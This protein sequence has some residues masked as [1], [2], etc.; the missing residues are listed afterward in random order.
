MDLLEAMRTRSSTRAFLERPVERATVEAILEA[1]RWAP[2]GVNIQPWRV[3]VVQGESRGRIAAAIAAA[4]AAGQAPNPDY[5]YYPQQWRE[6]YKER[7]KRCGLA[8]Y[9]ALGVGRDDTDAR[10]AAWERNYRFFDAPVGLLVFLERD[11]GQGAWVDLGMFIQN[12]LLAALPFGLATCPQAAMA[13]YPDIVREL[14]GVEPR[15]A[16]MCGIALGYPDPDAPVNRYRT[17]RE[18]VAEFAAFYE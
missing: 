3:A 12:V 9:R 11:L 4:R 18:P 5:T 16:L 7:R 14:L 8:M 17:E 1:A 15:F 13:E 6:P 2:S 10:N